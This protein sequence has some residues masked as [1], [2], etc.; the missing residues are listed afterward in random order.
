MKYAIAL[1]CLVSGSAVA[2]PACSPDKGAII[3]NEQAWTDAFIKSDPA[4]VKHLLADD[5]V[6]VSAKGEMYGRSQ[7]I[8]E[9]AGG[10][11]VAGGLGEVHVTFHGDTAIAQG[12]S[13]SKDK[14]GAQEHLIW[15]D[16]WMCR[17]GAWQ[18]VGAM[19]ARK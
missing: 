5:F 6:G 3:A 15:L 19:D 16:T 9:I 4:A 11:S 17:G 18:V 12:R 2:A 1:L 8:A 14:S 10:A 7:A 13:W